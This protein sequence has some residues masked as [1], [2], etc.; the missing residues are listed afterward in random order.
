[1]LNDFLYKITFKRNMKFILLLSYAVIILILYAVF[2]ISAESSFSKWIRSDMQKQLEGF[3]MSADAEYNVR[4][5]Y[6]ISLSSNNSVKIPLNLKLYA[7]VKEYIES[8][9]NYKK[10]VNKIAIVNRQNEVIFKSNGVSENIHLQ[11]GDEP[12]SCYFYD[13]SIYKVNYQPIEY[14]NIERNE[15]AERIGAVISS[16]DF[17]DFY[18]E[19]PENA[20]GVSYTYYGFAEGKLV[21][22]IDNTPAILNRTMKES[23]MGKLKEGS[24]ILNVDGRNVRV[25]NKYIPLINRK[26]PFILSIA[27]PDSQRRSIEGRYILNAV[28]YGSLVS[29]P[30][31]LIM[32]LVYIMLKKDFANKLEIHM[33]RAQRHDFSKH[34]GVVRGM[35]ALGEY[36][37]LKTYVEVLGEKVS[38]TTELSKLGCPPLGI[39]LQ[40]KELYAGE[41]DVD[42]SV[43][44][45]TSLVGIRA[46][47]SDLCTI[48]G[49]LV[50]NAIEACLSLNPVQRYVL[51]EIG[52]DVNNYYFKVTDNGD[53]ILEKNLGK[54]FRPG[55]T[56]RKKPKEHGMGLYIVGRLL[57]KYHG[58]IQVHSGRELTAIT[59][60][61]P[62]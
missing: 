25:F 52:T 10:S 5:S 14:E 36:E 41:N 17:L 12:Y 6:A 53:A 27:L 26:E 48:V 42:Y 3:I 11:A 19:V 24:G 7:Q 8:D 34:L 30:I 15:P 50:D 47:A 9:K 54:I 33:L 13:N 21:F 43:E 37:E 55:Y 56:T 4:I 49:N 20:E 62:R 18:S 60:F 39:L 16:Y 40:D 2:I 57:K 61:L 1:M 22:I 45:K 28:L 58:D 29:L 51:V 35:V 23:T 44:I 59:V 38:F 32:F 31:S 46:E